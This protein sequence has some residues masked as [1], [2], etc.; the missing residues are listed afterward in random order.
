[1]PPGG[2]LSV[3]RLVIAVA[4]GSS[5]LAGP[6]T[7][8]GAPVL[9][10][11]NHITVDDTG[12]MI[13]TLPQTVALGPQKPPAASFDDAL[14]WRMVMLYAL[15]EASA[16]GQ[17]FHPSVAIRSFSGSHYHRTLPAGDYLLMLASTAGRSVRATLTLPGLSGESRFAPATKVP[18]RHRLRGLHPSAFEEDTLVVSAM[19][20][21]RGES[22]G[23]MLWTEG[24]PAGWVGSVQRCDYLGNRDDQAADG[25]P[26]C[27]GGEVYDTPGSAYRI[28]RASV[29][30]S[31]LTTT[32][33]W[34]AG[35]SKGYGWAWSYTT[36]LGP[37]P[38]A[39]LES[40]WLDIADM[41]RELT[42]PPAAVVKKPKKRAAPGRSSRKKSCRRSK[43][44]SRAS[45][46]ASKKRS[47]RCRR[48][49]AKRKK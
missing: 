8:D 4:L 45:A 39:T 43:P 20:P 12:G 46:E 34:T 15:T 25:E 44:K 19:H 2:R 26:G 28:P 49:P 30:Q 47:K 23:T 5:A 42:E 41:P 22:F 6:A 36:L 7:A 13:V 17:T 35:P 40:W 31:R 27:P 14:S 48:K 9:G 33:S 24:L 29:S 1:M 32:Y 18:V 16:E 11:T 37:P 21:H 10:G 38:D 3:A